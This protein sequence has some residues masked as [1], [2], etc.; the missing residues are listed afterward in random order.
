MLVGNSL[1][2]GV[3][4]WDYEKLAEDPKTSFLLIS[5][6]ETFMPD[7][8]KLPRLERTMLLAAKEKDS[9]D[10]ELGPDPFLRGEKVREWVSENLDAETVASLPDFDRGHKLIGADIDNQTLVSILKRKLGL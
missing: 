9:P 7:P 1:G 8:S 6:T 2:A 5:P 10:S 3:I 4:L